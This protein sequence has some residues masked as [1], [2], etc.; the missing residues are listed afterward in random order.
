M[1]QEVVIVHHNLELLYDVMEQ[2]MVKIMSMSV[3]WDKYFSEIK[4]NL[5]N[6]DAMRFVYDHYDEKMEKLVKR[7]NRYGSAE[8][9][10]FLKTFERVC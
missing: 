8:S 6:R 2:N 5:K 4:A 7:R 9:Q 1:M 3:E 10:K